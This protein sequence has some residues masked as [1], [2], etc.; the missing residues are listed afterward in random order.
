MGGGGDSPLTAGLT[1]IPPEAQHA[2][3]PGDR[4]TL[5]L[6]SRVQAQI[7]TTRHSDSNP[8]RLASLL[9]THTTFTVF[10]LIFSFFLRSKHF[11]NLL[12]FIESSFEQTYVLTTILLGEYGSGF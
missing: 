10:V 8:N 3:P 7:Q 5:P 11:I 12:T 4:F 1:P 6:T 9:D 2:P